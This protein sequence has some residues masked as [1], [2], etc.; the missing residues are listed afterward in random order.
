MAPGPNACG[1]HIPLPT[2]GFRAVLGY[3][4]FHPLVFWPL[5]SPSDYRAVTMAALG[6]PDTDLGAGAVAWAG[7][8]PVLRPTC[9]YPVFGADGQ[10]QVILCGLWPDKVLRTPLTPCGAAPGLLR[11]ALQK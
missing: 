5:P 1:V 9:G 4:I 2:P 10:S 3:V 8:G 11:G 7:M 6:W